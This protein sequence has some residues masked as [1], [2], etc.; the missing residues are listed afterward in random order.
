MAGLTAAAVAAVAFLAYQASANAPD[1]VASTPG[2]K[3]SA[4]S[5]A[6]PSAKPKPTVDPLAVPAASGEGERVVYALKDR[7]V[8]LVDED[9]KAIRTF[10][11]MPS[12]VSPPPGS[13][14]VTSRSGTV[15]GSDGVPIEHVV[16]F[17]NVDEVTIGFSA[18][19]DGSMASPDPTS[20]TGG[21][22]MKRADGNAMWTFA[23]VGAKVVVVP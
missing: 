1:S 14:Q 21:I 13:H 19:Q 15:Q 5:S 3:P 11:V 23:T 10:T 20:K 6:Q 22:R 4:S 8:W 18:A 12:P 2:G 16:R 7:R 17:A 9:D